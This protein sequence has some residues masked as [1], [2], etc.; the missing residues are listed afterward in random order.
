MNQKTVGQI[1]VTFITKF[2][3]FLNLSKMAKSGNTDCNRLVK[4]SKLPHVSFFLPHVS[5][6]TENIYTKSVI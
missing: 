5:L 4:E 6:C 3:T 1:F 2:I